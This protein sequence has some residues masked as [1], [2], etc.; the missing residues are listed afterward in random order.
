MRVQKERVDQILAACRVTAHKLPDPEIAVTLVNK[1][2]DFGYCLQVQ[3]RAA[4]ASPEDYD[5]AKGTDIAVTRT[6][7]QWHAEVWA[8]EG[9]NM[10]YLASQ[11]GRLEAL[12]MC[13]ELDPEDPE[14]LLNAALTT[15]RKGGAAMDIAVRAIVAYI[16]MLEAKYE[17]VTS[18]W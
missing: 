15:F 14:R 12:H 7:S 2:T 4:A 8:H 10:M 17:G 11:H 3:G 18:G 9:W 1:V 6:E 13:Y 16:K 5:L